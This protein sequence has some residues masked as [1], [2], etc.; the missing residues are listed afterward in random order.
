MLPIVAGLL[1]A[2]D[3]MHAHRKYL[4][5]LR[6]ELDLSPTVDGNHSAATPGVLT[7]TAA[8][9]P[10]SLLL[11]L[12]PQHVHTVQDALGV[13]SY[14]NKCSKSLPRT[15]PRH[16]VL[17]AFVLYQRYVAPP[18]GLLPLWL[19]SLPPLDA[20]C[21]WSDAE[22]KLLDDER[23]VRLS[24]RRRKQLRRE[25]DEICLLYTSPSPRDGLLSRMPSSA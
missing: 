8:V 24:R 4:S 6:R 9:S 2:P 25:Y 11:V 19:E 5:A 16:F 18:K 10:R 23:A 20:T 13:V 1:G 21:L 12:P 3:A 15:L 7:A 22:L 17:A 14:I